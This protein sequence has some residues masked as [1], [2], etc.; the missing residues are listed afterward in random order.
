MGE[1]ASQEAGAS[2]A[3]VGAMDP[4]AMRRKGAD[5]IQVRRQGELPAPTLV[6]K[7][8]GIPTGLALLPFGN[9]RFSLPRLRVGAW[10]TEA[11][12]Y[13]LGAGAVTGSR[14]KDIVS[15]CR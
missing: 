5:P 9:E 12:L 8:Y 1:D 14:G 7:V 3:A 10:I 6:G 11:A 15:A 4:A 2:R 13:S